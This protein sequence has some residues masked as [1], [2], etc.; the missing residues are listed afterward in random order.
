MSELPLGLPNIGNFCYVNSVIQSIRHIPHFNLF[1]D[2]IKNEDDVIIVGILNILKLNEPK[3]KEEMKIKMESIINNISVFEVNVEINDVTTILKLDEFIMKQL[4]IDKEKLLFYL[5]L[6][7]NN[8]N[9]L[10]FYS[11]LIELLNDLD[12]NNFD[13]INFKNFLQFS[14]ECFKVNGLEY[15]FNGEQNDAG[16]FLSYL[17]YFINDTHIEPFTQ[18]KKND[19]LD[20]YDDTK[21]FNNNKND[22][23]QMELISNRINNLYNVFDYKLHKNNEFTILDNSM[24]SK[25]LQYIICQN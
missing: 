2:K 20:T 4:N 5:N 10:Y 19:V 21:Y 18:E 16:E 3:T 25:N 11:S 22:M 15:L 9:K 14:N 1:L 17:L 23:T 6:I 12:N 7:K 24:F 8:N 13:K